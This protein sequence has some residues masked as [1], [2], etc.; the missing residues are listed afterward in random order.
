M[1]HISPSPRLA[2]K[3]AGAGVDAVVAEGD[4]AGGH[5]GLEEITTMV[6][7]PLVV[8]KV[9]IPVIAAGGIADGRGFLAAL[10]LGAKG[11]QIGTRFAATHEAACHQNFKEAILKA[12]ES[13]TVITG[14]KIGPVR[15]IKNKLAEAILEAE[16]RGA[17]PQEIFEL[18]GTGR[19]RMASVDGNMEDGTI[20]CGQI[21]GI[22]SEIK[23]A[24]EVISDIIEG[25]E[26]V[27]ASL[28][29][30]SRQ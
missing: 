13:E 15:C 16:G 22:I 9:D 6:L 4:E 10:S 5:N 18:I 1:I 3:A 14:R 11:V 28:Q 19:L 7:I 21:A 12:G 8:E 2:L 17:T 30:I 20:Y 23:A 25:A 29:T 24:K 27:L 26:K